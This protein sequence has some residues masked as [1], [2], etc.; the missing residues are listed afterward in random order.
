MNLPVEILCSHFEFGDFDCGEPLQN[1]S[2]RSRTERQ[3]DP[4]ETVVFVAHDGPQIRGFLSVCDLLIRLDRDG[5]EE[6][7]FFFAAFGVD[8]R[9]A[10]GE[11]AGALVSSAYQLRR[12]RRR[13]NYAAT[14]ATTVD[15]PEFEP[16]LRELRFRPVP[17]TGETFWYRRP[18]W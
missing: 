6:R 10:G 4:G 9:W 11:L 18:G 7:C 12:L 13:K 17:N 15:N 3:V 2:L 14:V 8:R 5:T 16:R 1:A